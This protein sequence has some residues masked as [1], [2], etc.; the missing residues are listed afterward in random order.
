MNY[1]IM[2][3]SLLGALFL[4]S[5]CT[6]A[7]VAMNNYPSPPYYTVCSVYQQQQVA[8]TLGSEGVQI[9]YLGDYLTM[10]FPTQLFFQPVSSNLQSSAYEKLVNMAALLSCYRKID[11]RVTAYSGDFPISAKSLLLSEVQAQV[12]AN[13]LS[14]YGVNASIIYAQ[15]KGMQTCDIAPL[16]R[17]RIIV[18]TQLLP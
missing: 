3:F 13:I 7:P 11:I 9:T 10:T 4:L 8:N 2:Y 18:A 6:S 12:I 15:G 16:Q 1:R 17:S 14:G 5:A